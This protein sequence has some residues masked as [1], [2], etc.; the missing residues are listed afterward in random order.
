MKHED[1]FIFIKSNKDQPEVASTWPDVYQGIINVS[2]VELSF[3][4]FVVC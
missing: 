1:F 3:N 4:L 2:G